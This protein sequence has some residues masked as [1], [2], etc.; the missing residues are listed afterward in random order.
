MR[1]NKKR[2]S[3]LVDFIVLG[4]GC[5]VCLA[6]FAVVCSVGMCCMFSVLLK[7]AEVLL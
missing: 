1:D 2:V 5:V 7:A 6:A 4:G 3:W